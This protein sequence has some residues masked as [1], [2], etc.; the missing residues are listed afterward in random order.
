[1]IIPTPTRERPRVR[2]RMTPYAFF[3]QERRDYYRQ[4][5]VP[6]QFTAFSKECSSLW[7]VISEE[8][9]QKYQK[10]AEEDRD[11]YRREVMGNF[12]KSPAKDGSRRGRRKK[13][14]GQPKRNMCA[15]LHFCS[16]KRPKLKQENP[17]LSVGALAKQ[18][19][20]AWKLMTPEQKKPYD[21]LAEKDKQRYE[22]QKQAYEA[23]YSAAILKTDVP[24]G[25]GQPGIVMTT[26]RHRR[27]KKDPDMPRR[28][29]SAFM[30]YSLEKRPGVKA[31]NPDF[32]V[33]K[34]AQS[35][36]KEWNVLSTTDRQ[37]FISMA[38]K[39]KE[40][41]VAELKAYK[42][43]L[44]TGHSPSV[45]QIAGLIRG[46]PLISGSE[47]DE[48]DM[49]VMAGGMSDKIGVAGPGQ[50]PSTDGEEHDLERLCEFYQ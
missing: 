14:P 13:E 8:E 3:V 49:E 44:Y 20:S 50:S 9:K 4:Q 43:G 39:D 36:A 29:M 41:Y 10:L 31:L 18:L 35:L 15:F 1:M 26:P 48:D 32:G 5:G 19:S 24:G 37:P 12:D 28:N 2:G 17:S 6:V 11:R 38:Q 42:K 23:G 33:G 27:R 16:A 30:F 7:K 45:R 25:V 21:I 47:G 34:L 40:R 46:R 22:Q